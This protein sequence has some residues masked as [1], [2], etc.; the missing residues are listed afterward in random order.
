VVLASSLPESIL[1]RNTIAFNQSS[2][3]A[4][5]GGISCNAP[6]VAAAGNL[7]FH[8]TEGD[9]AGGTKTDAT[10]QKNDVSS[11]QYG[12]TL[13]IPTDAGNLGFKSPVIAPLDFHLTSASPPTIVDAGGTCSG[14]DLDGDARPIGAACDLGADEYHP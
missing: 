10:T 7:I 11:C 14:I 2:G 1:E 4:F 8:N 5:R 6:L 9:G 13:A 3:V 12:N